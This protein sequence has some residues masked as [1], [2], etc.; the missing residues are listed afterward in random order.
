MPENISE[1]VTDIRQSNH[2]DVVF[3]Q[4]EG[5]RAKYCELPISKCY[6]TGLLRTKYDLVLEKA[7]D[8]FVP[9][10]RSG[11]KTYRNTL[12]YLC[13][14]GNAREHKCSSHKPEESGYG[15]E[16]KLSF[17]ALLDFTESAPIVDAADCGINY[18]YDILKVTCSDTKRIT[19]VNLFC[20]NHGYKRIEKI[21]IYSA[22]EKSTGSK[23]L[24]K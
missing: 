12:C 19:N 15:P 17:S 22:K 20:G 11:K 7:C 5:F 14:A 3:D 8:A 6:E 1:I 23:F 2:S 13:N 18:V 9:E 10:F 4:P 21:Y 16:L 24:T